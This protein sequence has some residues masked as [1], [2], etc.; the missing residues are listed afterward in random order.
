MDLD[1]NPLSEGDLVF[2][3]RYDL[4]ECLIIRSES[5]IEY[6]SIGTG[7]RVSWT[8]MI[9][10]ATEKQKVNKITKE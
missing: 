10:A 7:K 6:E 8:L 5:G 9:D 2:S 1:N 3:H 4:G